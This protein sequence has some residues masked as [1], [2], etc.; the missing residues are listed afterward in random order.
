MTLLDTLGVLNYGLVLIYGLFLS[1][2]IA[3]GFADRTQKRLIIILCPLFLLIQTPCWLILG[4]SATKQLYPLIVHLP[5]IL[6]LIIALKKPVGIALVSVCTAY[7][8][9]QLP[10]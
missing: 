10:R 7:L 9:C 8:C 4:E 2:H 3:G 5:L 1:A 6:I